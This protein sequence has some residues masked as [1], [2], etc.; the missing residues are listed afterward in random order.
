[1]AG[2]STTPC[3]L[4]LVTKN[5]VVLKRYFKAKKDSQR[6][7]HSVKYSFNYYGSIGVLFLYWLAHSCS[8]KMPGNQFETLLRCAVCLDRLKN[9]KILPCQHTFCKTPCIEGLIKWQTRSIKCPECRQDHFVPSNGADGFPNNITILGFLDL[10]EGA[11]PAAQSQS[12]GKLH[13]IYLI[14]MK[15]YW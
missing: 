3:L 1:M 13:M 2:A 14:Q 9:P 6:A 4:T 7:E 5:V 11:V 12:G 10:P 15:C 8:P